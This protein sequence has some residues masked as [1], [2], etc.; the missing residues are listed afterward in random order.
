MISIY[1]DVDSSWK[2]ADNPYRIIAGLGGEGVSQNY[3]SAYY[4]IE[5]YRSDIRVSGDKIIADVL[6]G[7][8]LVTFYYS[9]QLKYD[10]VDGEWKYVPIHEN[11]V[12]SRQRIR[13][14]ATGT[15]DTTTNKGSFTVFY[16][17]PGSWFRDEIEN[18]E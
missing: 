3:S 7:D 2:L 10:F 1:Y 14:A 8:Y 17:G 5:S 16:A 9:M 4:K 13:L 18:P 12:S 15:L 11:M 6:R